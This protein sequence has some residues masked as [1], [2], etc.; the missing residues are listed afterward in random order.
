[1]RLDGVSIEILNG[2]GIGGATSR[3]QLWLRNQGIDAGRQA[4]LPPY[5]TAH[6]SCTELDARSPVSAAPNTRP[7]IGPRQR[8]TACAAAI[9]QARP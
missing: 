2:N 8:M 9:P 7:P 1:V 5:K 6:T 3:L 4:N